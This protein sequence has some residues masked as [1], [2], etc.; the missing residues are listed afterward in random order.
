MALFDEYGRKLGGMDKLLLSENG[1]P[2][3]AWEGEQE[4]I[5]YYTMSNLR[6]H[7]LGEY[8]SIVVY[9]EPEM[10]A[11]SVLDKR[12]VTVRLSGER[13]LESRLLCDMEGKVRHWS[14]ARHKVA[15]CNQ[16]Q[17]QLCK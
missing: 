8:I 10:G 11:P 1:Q 15:Q 13:N 3:S 6:D 9:R 4:E 12:I 5:D 7:V 2:T 17:T 14:Y 16:G